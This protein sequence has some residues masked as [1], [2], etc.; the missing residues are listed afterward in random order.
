MANGLGCTATPVSYGALAADAVAAAP[1]VLRGLSPQKSGA[2]TTKTTS[3]SVS[4]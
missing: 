2:Y 3:T 1:T 4:C